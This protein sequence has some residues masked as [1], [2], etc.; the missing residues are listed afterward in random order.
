MFVLS[1]QLLCRNVKDKESSHVMK[2]E[3]GDADCGYRTMLKRAKGIYQ[4]SGQSAAAIKDLINNLIV[5][6][7]FVF[8]ERP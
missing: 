3:T 1:E 4:E 2:I 8:N 5:L 7:D 6:T